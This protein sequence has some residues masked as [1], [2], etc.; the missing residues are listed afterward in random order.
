MAERTHSIRYNF[1]MNFILTAAQFVFPLISFPYV[2]RVL[3]SEGTGRVAFV[4]AVANYFLMIASLGIP[5]LS[6]IHI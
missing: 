4:S 3:L 2:S 5:T 6:L 1:L